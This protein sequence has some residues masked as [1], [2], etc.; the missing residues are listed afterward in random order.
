VALDRLT[1][2]AAARASLDR[3][4]P[5]LA[6]AAVDAIAPARRDAVRAAID[7]SFVH[8][9]RVVMIAAALVACAAAIAGALMP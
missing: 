2:P 3:E 7:E 1:L 9:F 4:L 8:A 5:R 6:G